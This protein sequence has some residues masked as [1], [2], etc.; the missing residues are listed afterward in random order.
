MKPANVFYIVVRVVFDNYI[1]LGLIPRGHKEYG[2]KELS[3]SE[4]DF[5]KATLARIKKYRDKQ[6]L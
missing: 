1:K 4:K 2:F 6:G 5:D 3:W